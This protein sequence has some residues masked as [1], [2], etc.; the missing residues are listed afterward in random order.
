MKTLMALAAFAYFLGMIKYFLHLAVKR[1]FL[2]Y[3]ATLMVVVGFVLHTVMLFTLS[4]KTGHGPYT[5]SFE[6]A[7]FFAWTTMGVLIAVLFFY[8]VSTLGAFVA[9]VG[10]LSMAYS[11]L[12]TPPDETFAP[13]KAF[14]NTMHFTLS[15]LALSS[16][17]VVFAASL[18]YLIQERQLK[19]HAGGAWLGRMPNLDILDNIFYGSLVFGFPLITVGIGSGLIWSAAR[20]GNPLGP[21][22]AKIF[23]LILVWLIYAVLVAGRSAFGWRGHRIAMLG[24]V[25]FAAALLAL[26]IHLY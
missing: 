5:N 9:P 18:M 20:Y 4:A 14:W 25:G 24:A 1:K 23:P 13:A 17:V 21:Y 15:F 12:L 2:F 8:R 16:F 19:K 26:G 22:P 11:F 3:L 6:Y 7:S 10:F